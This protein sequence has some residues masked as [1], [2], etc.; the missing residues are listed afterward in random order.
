M[1]EDAFALRFHAGGNGGQPPAGTALRVAIPP[2]ARR[3]ALALFGQAGAPMTTLPDGAGFIWGRLHDRAGAPVGSVAPGEARAWV[4]TGGRRLIEAWWGSYVAVLVSPGT[5]TIVRDPSGTIP[6]YYRH[7]P[8]GLVAAS[9]TIRAALPGQA[10]FSLDW[11]EI[12]SVL[13][14]SGRRTE[15]TGLIGLKELLPGTSLEIGG[16]AIRVHTLW[17]PYRHVGDWRRP[18]DFEAARDAVREVVSM[19]VAAQARPFRRPL[20]ELSGGVDSSVV[21]AALKVAGAEALCLTF[22]GGGGDMDETDHARAVARHNSLDWRSA[23]LRTGDVDLRRCDGADTP[24]PTARTF[25]QAVDRCSM[26]AAA[27]VG[28][29]AFFSGGGGDNVF[30]YFPT[31]APALDRLR[32][33]GLAGFATTI[34]DLCAMTGATRTDAMRLVARRMFRRK[35]LPWPNDVSL[36][37]P[38]AQQLS[39]AAPHPWLPAPAG[40]LPGVRAYA[41]VLVRMQGHYEWIRRAEQAP[42]LAPLLSQPVVEACLRLP[43]WLWCAGGRNRAVARAAFAPEFPESVRAR[44]AKGGFDGFTHDVLVAQRAAARDLLL[45]GVLAREGLIDVHAIAAMLD[46]PSRIPHRCSKRLLWLAGVE[47]WLRVWA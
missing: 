34:D 27:E 25:F 39:A 6:C 9:D 16:K 17:D 46:D 18:P 8:D 28:C 13:Q 22:R 10:R 12:L 29:D 7:S 30:W 23:E 26:A 41:R 2:Q 15:R 42:V 5:V 47:A 24:R 4:A 20:V 44:S 3:P 31:V 35:P 36:L 37:V 11:D 38:A 1:R 19:V 40:I 45:G 43:S 14:F 21:T 33:E 32:C